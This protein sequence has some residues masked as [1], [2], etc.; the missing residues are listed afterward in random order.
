MQ[1]V[2]ASV[3]RYIHRCIV[4]GAAVG[5]IFVL[6]FNL[7]KYSRNGGRS[8]DGFRTQF[9]GEI[10]ISKDPQI[11]RT[12]VCGGDLQHLVRL[13]N[14]LEIDRFFDQS[15]FRFIRNDGAGVDQLQQTRFDI[16]VGKKENEASSVKISG[17]E[18]Q[19]L[20]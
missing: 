7:G 3:Y 14:V 16:I 6:D 17:K 2:G 18:R 4:N 13:A 10:F 11:P 15:T 9:I 19:V 20:S 5:V 12:P 8:Q 1:N